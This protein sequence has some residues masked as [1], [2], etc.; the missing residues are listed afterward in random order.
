[1]GLHRNFSG[2]FATILFL[3]LAVESTAQT[4]F[5]F[6]ELKEMKVSGTSTIHDWEMVAENGVSATASMSLENGQL[7]GIFCLKVELKAESLKSGNKGMDTNAYKALVTDKYSTIS[8]ELV[9][10]AKISGNKISASGRMTISGTS[11]TIP[12]VVLYQVNGTKITF[13][14]TKE[15]KF[16]DY[17]IEPPK[18]VFGTI[19]TGNELTLSF[20]IAL[21]Q[22]T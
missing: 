18:A 15:I 12:M 8:F 2:F 10:P 13:S 6:S 22:K 11:Q 17:N 21:T 19:K 20:D 16:T 4:K 5:S 7:K 1:M 3:L 9:G 14:G